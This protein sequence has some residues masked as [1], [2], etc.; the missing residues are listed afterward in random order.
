MG[1]KRKEKMMWG[2]FKSS[3]IAD[4][5]IILHDKTLLA[6]ILAP[7]ILIL[8]LKFVF[9]LLSGVIFSKT[10]FLLDKYY[11]LVA[12]TFVSVIPMLS[13]MVYA[14]IK[15]NEKDLNTMRAEA[16]ASEDRYKFLLLRMT[17]PVLISFVLVMITIILV[18][19]VPTEGWLRN[20]FATGLLSIQSAFVFQFI[21]SLSVNRVSGLAVSRIY[22]IFIITVPLGLLF[23]HPWNYL[24][25]FSPLYWISWAWV[26]PNPA[27]SF[28]YG[29][30]AFILTSGSILM[31]LRHFMRRFII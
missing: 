21:S 15:I 12:I 1:A 14:F 25:F 23:H 2:S 26:V 30:I 27:E 10:G 22:W 16:V 28:V 7:F 6:R 19:P 13:G 5:N 17:I 18:K 31:L 9:P 24:A 20:L 8:L 3:F 29:V 4:C 11:S